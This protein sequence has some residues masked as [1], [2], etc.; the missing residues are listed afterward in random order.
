MI[1]LDVLE[2]DSSFFKAVCVAI[3]DELNIKLPPLIKTIQSDISS[4]IGK[5]FKNTDEYSLLTT[6]E[7]IIGDTGLTH[8]RE[9]QI[10]ETI[11]N[12]IAN[13]ITVNYEKLVFSGVNLNGGFNIGILLSDYS[14]ILSLEEA[15]FISKNGVNEWLKWILLSGSE[16]VINDYRVEYGRF[17]RSGKAHMVLSGVWSVDSRIQGTQNDNWLTR[18]LFNNKSMVEEIILNAVQKEMQRIL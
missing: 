1:T 14:D 8:G 6:D 5:V 16:I 10:L 18:A 17:G 2:T 13:S 7:Q 11:I 3:C 4:N 15:R 9:K 12:R